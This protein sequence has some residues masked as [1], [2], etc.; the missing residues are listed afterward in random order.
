MKELWQISRFIWIEKR[1]GLISLLFGFLAAI[2][3]VGLF[4]VNGYLIAIAALQPPMYVLIIMVAIVKAGSVLRAVSRYAERYYSHRAT[5]TMLSHI[6]LYFYDRLDPI[7]T[8]LSQKYRSGD[9]L[10]RIVGDIESLQHFYLRVIYPPIIMLF[11]F[12][13]TL[14]FVSMFSIPI[15]MVLIIGLFITGF[16]LPAWFVL[17]QRK[18]H[19]SIRAKRAALSTDVTEWMY[20]YKELKLY[21]KLNTKEQQLVGYAADYVEEQQNSGL[22]SVRNQSIQMSVSLGLAWVVLVVGAYIVASGEMEGIFLAMLVMI[23]FTVFEN[24]APMAILPIHYDESQQAASRLSDVV[25]VDLAENDTWPL[26]SFE[27][28]PAIELKDVQYS[29]PGEQRVVLQDVSL[30]LPAG[31]KT[32]IVGPSGSGKSTLLQLLLKINPINEGL[33]LMGG[34][35]ISELMPEQVW[36]GTNVI[37]QRNHFFFGSI[38]DNLLLTNAAWSD[39]QLSQLLIDVQLPH[40]TLTDLVLEKGQNLSGGEQQRLAM[41]RAIVKGGV[42]WLLDEPVS[43]LDGFTARILMNVLYQHASK[44]TLVMISHQLEGL[45]SMDQIIVMDEGRIIE[46]G[47]YTSLMKQQGYFYKLKQIEQSIVNDGEG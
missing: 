31:S 3:V 38:R 23:A 34:I 35:P 28:A 25:R 33:I 46:Y 27:Q 30:H 40:F 15:M 4:A 13:A 2:T 5:F 19:S 44:D 7:A 43:A 18:Q 1:D 41:A 36:Q 47:S 12:L 11:V 42:L 39:E 26:Q 45:E 17:R 16:V 20:G 14:L 9:L 8:R 10:A 29:Y 37:L 24:A 21:Q 6:R 32:A 22:E